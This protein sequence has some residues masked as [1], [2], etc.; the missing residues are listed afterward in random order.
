[1]QACFSQHTVRSM[2]FPELPVWVRYRSLCQPVI[3]EVAVPFIQFC[4]GI[5]C[6]HGFW[7]SLESMKDQVMV[8]GTNQ[9]KLYKNVFSSNI[10]PSLAFIGFTQPA[11]GGL[12]GMSEMQARWFS[13]L[14]KGAVKLPSKQEMDADFE[15][16]TVRDDIQH[17]APLLFVTIVMIVPYIT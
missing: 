14:C 7:Q 3:P 1:M 4:P 10:G 13:K 15:A 8:K 11:S 2:G 12:L 17:I 9:I 6:Q 16:E 5:S